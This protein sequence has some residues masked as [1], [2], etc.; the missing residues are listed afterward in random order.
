VRVDLALSR[1][2][3]HY[4][5]LGVLSKTSP[6]QISTV[7]GGSLLYHEIVE[8]GI[9]ASPDLTPMQLSA[10]LRR[11]QEKAQLQP[12]IAAYLQV[13][14]AL[15]P[16]PYTPHPKP[17]KGERERLTHT[18]CA[19]AHTH[20]HTHTEAQDNASTQSRVKFLKT[21]ALFV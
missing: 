14:R 5:N 15:H 19:R 17:G 18:L 13:P 20:T 12:E 6:G 4:V 2:P 21:S 9:E 10:Q 8:E 7:E 3:E 1:V 11:M 16:T